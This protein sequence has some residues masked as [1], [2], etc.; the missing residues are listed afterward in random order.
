MIDYKN[1]RPTGLNLFAAEPAMFVL[2]YLL[3]I[4]QRVGVPAHRGVAVEDGVVIGLED[5]KA[6]IKS[7]VA[8]AH[9]TYDRLMALSGD[10]RREKYRQ[11]I[12]DMV[13]RAV[14]ELRKYGI[15]SARQ[16]VVEW[17]P[18]QLRLPIRGHFDFWWEDHGLI[19]DL[20]TTERMPSEIKI[21]HARQVSHYAAS[22]NVDARLA[23]VTPL[24]LEV[25]GLENVERHREALLNIAKKVENLLS[26]SDDPNFFLGLYAPNLDSFF[27]NNPTSRQLAYEMFGV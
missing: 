23:Y 25:Y 14:V 1:H 18:E 20:K 7:C 19:L 21:S 5:P 24:K 2:E 12:G 16:G 26:L 13:E 8:E 9:K 10:P 4:K 6:S 17:H 15:P 11:P 22:N 27:W 3:G